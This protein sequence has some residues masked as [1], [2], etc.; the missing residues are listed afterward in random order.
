MQNAKKNSTITSTYR[1]QFMLFRAITVQIWIGYLF[2]LFPTIALGILIFLQ[3]HNAGKYASLL[4]LLTS[5]HNLLDYLTIIYFI[6]PYRKTVMKWL[7]L[8]KRY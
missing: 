1:L 6:I 4:I 7:G 8:Q 5:I 2:L 3:V